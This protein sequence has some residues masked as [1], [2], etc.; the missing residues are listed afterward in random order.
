MYD[1]LLCMF[2]IGKHIFSEI[3]QFFARMK[4]KEIGVS[5][6]VKINLSIYVTE[7]KNVLVEF[8]KN[9]TNLDKW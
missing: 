6:D 4:S 1:M 9:T 2:S 3:K 7:K 5:N 8:F